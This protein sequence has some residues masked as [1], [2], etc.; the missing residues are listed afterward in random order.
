MIEE[1]SRWVFRRKMMKEEI[2]MKAEKII[3]SAQILINC[4]W[5]FD[6]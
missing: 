2:Q 3:E 5:W 4:K 6:P 1:F